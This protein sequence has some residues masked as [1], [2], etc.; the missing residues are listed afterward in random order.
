M[1][2]AQEPRA[3]PSLNYVVSR[4]KPANITEFVAP[5][6]QGPGTP[7]SPHAHP[8]FAPDFYD[9]SALSRSLSVRSFEFSVFRHFFLV[10][11]EYSDKPMVKARSLPELP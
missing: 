11:S 3:T 1:K 8:W 5:T 10:L 2:G 4:L 9:H 6:Y 7:T